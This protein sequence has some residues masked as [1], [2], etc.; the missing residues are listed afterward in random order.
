MEMTKE[1]LKSL[2]IVELKNIC[3]KY[4]INQ[5]GTK[6][7]LINKIMEYERP[8]PVVVHSH[9]A[10]LSPKGKKIIGVVSNDTEKSRQ[11]GKQIEQKKASFLYYS[12]GVRYF[13]VDED[14]TFS[15]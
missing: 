14:F 1:Q 5:G 4:R 6:T 12:M 8:A 7:Q 11:V 3:K 9:P 13:T 10:S 15:E 2:H